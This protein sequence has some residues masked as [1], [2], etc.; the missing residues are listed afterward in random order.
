VPVVEVN[1]T[2]LPAQKVVDP[3]AEMTG[4]AGNALTVTETCELTVLKPS[5]TA[6]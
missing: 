5:L 6:T 1:N 3:V 4:C 2:L